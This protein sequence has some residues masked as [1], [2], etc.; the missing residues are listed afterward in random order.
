M[1]RGHYDECVVANGLQRLKYVAQN[2]IGVFDRCRVCGSIGGLHALF[3]SSLRATD[4]QPLRVIFEPVVLQDTGG[5]G[6][7]ETEFWEVADIV[8]DDANCTVR[9]LGERGCRQICTRD[10]AE[11]GGCPAGRQRGRD[12]R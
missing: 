3:A 6:G 10:E 1:I 2:T 12:C 11:N 4:E 8:W 7:A 5:F 9:P